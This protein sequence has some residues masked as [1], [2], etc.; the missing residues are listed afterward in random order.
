[1]CWSLY[2]TTGESG[3]RKADAKSSDAK[4]IS[5][6]GSGSEAT[7]R[8]I[9]D[10]P[11]EPETD[12]SLISKKV[13]ENT[14][15]DV[16]SSAVATDAS[17]PSVTGNAKEKEEVKSANQEDKDGKTA[18]TS[19]AQQQ[20]DKKERVNRER[21]ERERKDRPRRP[22]SP[23]RPR[24]QVLTFQHIRVFHNLKQNNGRKSDHPCVL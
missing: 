24:Q 15:P 3:P 17:A 14:S 21:L 23:R 19:S 11:E 6:T 2:Q 1:M 9:T 13:V 7:D 20:R 5:T 18:V 22:P 12:S 10:K 16:A 4:A 8:K